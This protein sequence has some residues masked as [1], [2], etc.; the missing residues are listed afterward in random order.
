MVVGL[1][2]DMLA[3]V[4]WSRWVAIDGWQVNPWGEKVER[5]GRTT[6]RPDIVCYM[7]YCRGNQLRGWT[8]AEVGAHSV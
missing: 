5:N 4:G 1:I 6:S 2:D 8:G 7:P 3:A